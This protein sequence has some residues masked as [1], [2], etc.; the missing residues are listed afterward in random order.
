MKTMIT[1]IVAVALSLNALAH[2]GDKWDEKYC[3]RIK[4]GKKTIVHRGIII[5][6]EVTLDN[7]SRI[8]PDGTIIRKDGSQTMLSEG[9]CIDKSGDITAENTK[10]PK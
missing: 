8:Q 3:L 10:N 4:N 6:K 9:E 7:G 5:T 1:L 2:E